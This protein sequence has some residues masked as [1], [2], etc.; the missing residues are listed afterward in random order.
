MARY[1]TIHQYLTGD[2]FTSNFWSEVDRVTNG[3]L[4]ILLPLI[5]MIGELDE[6][7]SVGNE[8]ALWPELTE[9]HQKLHNIVAEAAWLAN[10]ISFSR[11]C[12]WV[13]FSQ[14]GQLWDI[15]QEHAIATNWTESSQAAADLFE[16]TGAMRTWYDNRNAAFQK[17]GQP[18]KALEQWTRNVYLPRNPKPRDPVR[19]TAKVQIS[20]WPFLERYFPHRQN[21]ANGGDTNEGDFTNTVQKAQVVYYAGEDSDAGEQLEEYTLSQ[22]L[23]DWEKRNTNSVARFSK[24]AFALLPTRSLAALLWACFALLLLSIAGTTLQ[25]GVTRIIHGHDS[26][27]GT[28]GRNILGYNVSGPI[29]E[30]T[31]WQDRFSRPRS[32]RDDNSAPQNDAPVPKHPLGAEDPKTT[33]TTVGQAAPNAHDHKTGVVTKT[34]PYD[35]SFLVHEPPTKPPSAHDR[36]PGTEPLVVP[37]TDD[38]LDKLSQRTAQPEAEALPETPNSST[39]SE[40]PGQPTGEQEL[41]DESFRSNPPHISTVES[42]LNY[43]SKASEKREA[44][45]S[46][47]SDAKGEASGKSVS[48]DGSKTSERTSS[49]KMTISNSDGKESKT[50][51]DAM[52]DKE[53][54]KE[55]ASD[56]SVSGNG[57]ASSQTSVSLDSSSTSKTSTSAQSS[58]SGVVGNESVKSKGSADVKEATKSG[59]RSKSWWDRI[60][61]SFKSLTSKTSLPDE[62][63]L[64]GIRIEQSGKASTSGNLRVSEKGEPSQKTKSSGGTTEVVTQDVTTKTASSDAGA[65]SATKVKPGMLVIDHSKEKRQPSVDLGIDKD[66]QDDSVD[67]EKALPGKWVAT[68]VFGIPYNCWVSAGEATCTQTVAPGSTETGERAGFTAV[69]DTF[70]DAQDL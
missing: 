49:G 6:K 31:Y 59:V 52:G 7:K 22:H 64:S 28:H 9:V 37:I 62:V 39:T 61:D 58:S 4:V 17:S 41:R 12:F 63:T 11:S 35:P 54:V 60:G 40:L 23:S 50:S 13:E 46:S 68:Q 34:I 66:S 5:N 15:R 3:I 2:L 42:T 30:N 26:W 57:S 1:D 18:D 25:H 43:N 56:K 36:Q 51:R 69:G 32:L 55:K 67:D 27:L 20:M 70:L 21:T 19:R 33:G 65:S 14:P 8:R 44:R 38:V 24:A 47:K 48:N 10:G 45:V 53:K 16:S 29:I